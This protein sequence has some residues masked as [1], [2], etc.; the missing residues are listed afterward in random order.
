MNA[1][2]KFYNSFV[3]YKK[4]YAYNAYVIYK[5]IQLNIILFK[6]SLSLFNNN[7]RGRDAIKLIITKDNDDFTC[8]IFFFLLLEGIIYL[9]TTSNEQRLQVEFNNTQTIDHTGLYPGN[10]KH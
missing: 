5:F 2:I 6:L 4:I 3:I 10:N 9:Y 7:R 1:S 8:S